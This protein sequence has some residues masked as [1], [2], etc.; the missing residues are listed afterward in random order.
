MRDIFLEFIP[1]ELANKILIFC[2]LFLF[3]LPRL[4]FFFFIDF[5]LVGKTECLEALVDFEIEFDTL[6]TVTFLSWEVI[7]VEFAFEAK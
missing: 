7:D 3:F 1:F 2:F 6:D 4:I 5:W